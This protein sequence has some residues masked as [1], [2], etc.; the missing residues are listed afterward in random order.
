LTR[1]IKEHPAIVSAAITGSHARQATDRFSDLDILVVT[2]DLQGVCDVRAWFPS[3]LEVL[4]CAFHLSRYCSVLLRDSQ[5]I[6]LAIF[7]VED[8]PSQWVIH[9]YQIIKGGPDFEAQLAQSAKATREDRAVHLNPDISLD[10]VLLLLVTAH[11]RTNRGELLSAHQFLAMACDMAIAL[12][13]N[14]GEAGT[15][16]D[17]LDP[18]RRLEK[19]DPSLASAIHQCLFAT[20]QHGITQLARYLSTSLRTNLSANQLQI[21]TDLSQFEAL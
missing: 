6:D 17:F 3:S 19:T 21:L 5:K 8:P 13:A 18:R 14:H 2:R 10:N 1:A 11:H 4:L 16:R 7:A 20:P 12:Q 9:D 15:E